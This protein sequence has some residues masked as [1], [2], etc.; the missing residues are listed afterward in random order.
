MESAQ[1]SSSDYSSSINELT[2]DD[3]PR[4]NLTPSHDTSDRQGDVSLQIYGE[5]LVGQ[6]KHEAIDIKDEAVDIEESGKWDFL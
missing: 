3:T 5:G 1:G 2:P 6:I 4:V